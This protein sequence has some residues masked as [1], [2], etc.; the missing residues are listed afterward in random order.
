MASKLGDK[1]NFNSMKSSAMETKQITQAI[2]PR[3]GVSFQPGQ[4]IEFEV[5]G[6]RPVEFLDVVNNLRVKLPVTIAGA[7]AT[8]D[9]GGVYSLVNK[10]EF[11]QNGIVLCS[12][13][14]ANVLITALCDFQMSAEYKSTTGAL[15]EGF[16]AD[17]LRGAILPVGEHTFYLAA[18]ATDLAMTTPHRSLYMGSSGPIT[19][20]LTLETSA[21]ALY[22]DGATTPTYSVTRPE[23]LLSSTYL[24]KETMDALDRQVGGNYRML[25]NSYD[26]MS[27]VLVAGTTA[28][29][30]KLSFAK[31]SLE[32]IIFTIRPAAHTVDK[33]K[34]SLGSRGTGTIQTFQLNVAGVDYPQVAIKADDRG[35]D[36]L[37]HLLGADNIASNYTQGISGLMNAYTL[38]ASGTAGTSVI[39]SLP[40]VE[41]KNP[42]I[43]PGADAGGGNYGKSLGATAAAESDI[44]T[45]LFAVN[46]ESNLVTSQ[47]S[48]IY[49][50]INTQ[51]GVDM[52]FKATFT[53]VPV[54]MVID[55]FALSTELIYLD[56]DQN[57]WSKSN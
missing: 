18:L 47:N 3:S 12:L 6:N 13:P 1:L 33:N 27:A 51:R 50:G 11:I 10:W 4:V 39:G 38:N 2:P 54:D 14:K 22:G 17:A 42:F 15:L 55:F 45:A 9:R 53:S 19:L 41:K 30:I 48:P 25:A 24:F 7:T 28:A 43:R 37:Y 5:P 40:E 16:C 20:R 46:L 35:S 26:H 56:R 31:A 49:S 44:G 8:L 21:I 57:M 52:Y 34:F 23:L 29:N 36:F 32:R